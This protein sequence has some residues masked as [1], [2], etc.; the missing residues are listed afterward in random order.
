MQQG[1]AV[2][3]WGTITFLKLKFMQLKFTSIIF[4][5]SCILPENLNLTHQELCELIFV[6]SSNRT[7]FRRIRAIVCACGWQRATL[8]SVVVELGAITF[9]M[10]GLLQPNFR[11][12]FL[13]WKCILPQNLRSIGKVL[14]ELFNSEYSCWMKTT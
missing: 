3:V 7:L 8:G 5:L 13:L 2:V 1:W 10:L 4:R 14:F 11:R 9:N 12:I 6:E